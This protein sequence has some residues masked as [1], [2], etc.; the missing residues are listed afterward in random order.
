MQRIAF[1]FLLIVFGCCL[2]A[3]N[4]C[5]QKDI[6]QYISKKNIDNVISCLEN[7]KVNAE[8]LKQFKTK[9]DE[10]IFHIAAKNNETR[11]ISS[12]IKHYPETTQAI[13][14]NQN[15]HGNTPLHVASIFNS[16]E[17]ITTLLESEG[18]NP[19]QKDE[20]NETP[21]HTGVQYGNTE[22]V[23][24]LLQS[25]NIDVNAQNNHGD[26]PL[27]K[28]I[29][30]QKWQAAKE[31]SKHE[32]ININ[33]MNALDKTPFDIARKTGDDAIIEIF[34]DVCLKEIYAHVQYMTTSIPT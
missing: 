22:A 13:I 14:N 19:N 33:I 10:N 20:F 4:S 29:K 34:T 24:A 2:H 25:S 6:I 27:H 5:S 30:N 15:R 28:A 3:S 23:A 21:L 17:V 18:I 16:P 11:M 1:I 26:T 8:E 31:L 7:K 9:D 32:K 12:V